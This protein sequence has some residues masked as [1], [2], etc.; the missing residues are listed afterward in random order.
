MSN[1]STCFE[2]PEGADDIAADGGQRDRME[3]TMLGCGEMSSLSLFSLQNRIRV[4]L[5]DTFGRSAMPRNPTNAVVIPENPKNPVPSAPSP[6]NPIVS[7]DLLVL[8]FGVQ[9]RQEDPF[10]SFQ[11]TESDKTAPIRPDFEWIAHFVS[12]MDVS[13]FENYS[14]LS[15]LINGPQPLRVNSM[16]DA[17]TTDEQPEINSTSE[18]DVSWS[19]SIRTWEMDNDAF[20][21]ANRRG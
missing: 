13:K 18:Y 17:R 8:H 10:R 15:S 16:C 7:N 1:E 20:L 2:Q 5:T 3:E 14:I 6:P 21:T 11:S 4:T 12:V 19:S 9:Y